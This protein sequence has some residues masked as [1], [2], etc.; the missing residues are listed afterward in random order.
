MTNRRRGIFIG[1]L[2]ALLGTASLAVAVAAY[3]QRLPDPETADRRGLFRWLIECDLREQ[4]AEL[5]LIILRRVEGELRAGID[6]SKVAAMLDDAQRQRLLANAD[7]LARRWFRRAANFYFAEPAGRR[8][9]ILAQQIEQ[10][11][12]L[13]IMDQ[14]SALERGSSIAN[15]EPGKANRVVANDWVSSL[16]AQT[17][18]IQT[19]LDDTEPQER[20]R[21]EQYFTALRDRLLMDSVRKF[22]PVF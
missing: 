18:R 2:L 11:Q 22:L 13:G 9:P 12:G 14:L 20:Q 7:L 4:P 19:W 3:I 8:G 1:L 10:I 17:K 16:A 6:F 21:M 15:P 5:Q